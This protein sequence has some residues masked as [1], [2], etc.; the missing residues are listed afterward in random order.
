M[1][2]PEWTN[3]FL[4]CPGC[5]GAKSDKWPKRS[6]YIRPDRGDPARTSSSQK[7]EQLRLPFR[8]AVR[9]E[10]CKILI[11]GGIG[12]RST[13][14]KIS[15]RCSNCSQRQYNFWETATMLRHADWHEHF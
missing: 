12:C 4:G 8:T 7:R 11:Y 5:N 10:R 14:N 13:E 3:Y 2:G 9:S 1:S 6:G 15:R